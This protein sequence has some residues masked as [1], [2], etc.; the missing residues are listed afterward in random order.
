M[1]K[2]SLKKH[3]DVISPDLQ[4]VDLRI[5][6]QAEF[7]DPGIAGYVQ[8]ATDTGGK[9]IRPALVF[10][11]ARAS[12]EARETHLEL[13]VIVELI[14]LASLI[15]D[16]VLDNAQIRRALPTMNAKWGTEISVLLGDCLFA[17]ALKLCTRFED[18]HICRAIADAA[19]EVC[20]GEILQTQR[21]F[22]LKLSVPDYTKIISMKTAALFR[23]SSELAAALNQVSEE[24]RNVYRVY[25]ETL[26]LAYQIYDDCLDLY[27][28]ESGSGKTLGTDLKKGKLTLPMLHMLQQL[29]ER[30][31]ADVSEALLHGSDADRQ[32]LADRVV[33]M[34][35]LSY[36]IRKAQDHLEK[37]HRMLLGLREN[38]HVGILKSIARSFIDEL[39]SM[40]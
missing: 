21:R 10:L 7:F 2:L 14:H 11:S 37:A 18:N 9:R 5:R 34:G 39:E 30:A 19:N 4:T 20:T 28:T 33:E 32:L 6:Q 12:G 35:G 16:D 1:R 17:H 40:K 13:A 27:G 24:E 25:G 22:D 31:L 26:G 36:S 15:H 38:E 3:F 23:V 8:Y 29:D